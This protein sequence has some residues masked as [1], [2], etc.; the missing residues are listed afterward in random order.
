MPSEINNSLQFGLAIRKF[1]VR[2]R[3][4]SFKV[5]ASD[6]RM[7]VKRERGKPPVLPAGAPSLCCPRNGKSEHAH[8]A[9]GALP[10]RPLQPCCGKAMR[11]WDEPGDRPWHDG[12]SAARSREEFVSAVRAYDRVLLSGFYVVPLF[13]VSHQWF[14]YSSKLAHPQQAARYAAPLYGATLDSWWRVAP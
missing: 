3:A 10:V 8:P 7:R 14:A 4:E 9:T 11:A 5:S 13:H 6:P 2:L 1:A 12:G